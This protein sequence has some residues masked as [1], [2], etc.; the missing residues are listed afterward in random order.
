[1]VA[2]KKKSKKRNALETASP[3]GAYFSDAE[4]TKLAQLC[5]IVRFRQG[6]Q[7]PESPFYLVLDGI[8]AVLDA[9]A[10]TELTSRR[11]GSFFTRHAGQG[12]VSRGGG[13]TSLQTLLVGKTS[14]HVLVAPDEEALAVFYET[15]SAGSREGYN[16]IVSTNMATV[17]GSVGF[18]RDAALDAVA[19]RKLGE[20]CSYVTLHPQDRV[21]EQGDTADAFFIILKGAVQVVLDEKALAGTEDATN[22]VGGITKGYG[23]TFGVASFVLGSSV[24]QFTMA[25]TELSLFVRVSS[26]DFKPFLASSPKLEQSLLYSTKLFLLKGYQK[27]PSSI[28]SSFT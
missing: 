3:L 19:M 13:N 28:F 11:A 9:T 8:V 25:A 15:L 16:A 7:L 2:K 18:I 4:L 14:G 6:R 27:M 26:K 22:Q 24:R 17:L 23:E 10:T 12:N 1:M 21:F 5:H 20:L